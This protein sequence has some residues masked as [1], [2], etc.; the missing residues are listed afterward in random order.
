[1]EHKDSIINKSSKPVNLTLSLNS[2]YYASDWVEFLKSIDFDII[3][4]TSS[5]LTAMRN[6]TMVVV[7]KHQVNVEIT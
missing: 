5:S 3:N 7:G 2:T 6:N 1:M 4:Q